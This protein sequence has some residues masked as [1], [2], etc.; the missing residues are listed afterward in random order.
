MAASFTT[1]DPGGLLKLFKDAI[2]N[3]T[4]TTW[5]YDDD[6][7]FY[8]ADKQFKGTAWFTPKTAK[9]ELVFN[10]IKSKTKAIT[11]FVYAYYHGHIIETFLFHFDNSFTLGAATAWATPDDIIK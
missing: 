2:D 1:S 6:G 4:V 5:L 9:G 10:I 7:D 8:H 11:P 3:K